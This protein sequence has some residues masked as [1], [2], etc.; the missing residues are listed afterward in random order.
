MNREYTFLFKNLDTD[1]RDCCAYIRLKAL[2]EKHLDI[3]DHFIIHGSCYCQSLTEQ[4][5]DFDNFIS[6][7]TE[8]E[9]KILCDP[10][11]KDLSSI[12]E[13]LESDENECVFED[14]IDHETEWLKE[15]FDLHDWDIEDI[16][17]E[18]SL[19]YRDRSIV[20]YVFDDVIQ[21][22]YEEAYNSGY[23][24]DWISKKYFDY[25]KFGEDL[26]EEN[27]NYMELRNGRCVYL[28]Y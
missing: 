26:L 16:F 6:V 2:K 28:M 12:I 27:D 13:K 21:L 14:V 1:D 8:E 7:L 24:D 3:D 19:D 20:G 22:G 23:I 4:V 17:N 25:R 9:L 10:Y 5:I 15:N 11:G 18:Y